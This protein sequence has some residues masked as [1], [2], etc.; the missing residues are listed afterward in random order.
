M[1]ALSPGLAQSALELMRLLQRQSLSTVE[2]LAGLKRIGNIATADA[3]DL[4]QTLNWLSLTTD[5]VLQA[6][7]A[8]ER[9]VAITR[10]D[11]ALRQ[12]ML[13]FVDFV[14]PDWLQNATYGRARVLSFAGIGVAQ[15]L[16]EAGVASGIDD[17]VVG[18]WD[19]LAARARGQ[20]DD[21]MLAIG[22]AGERLSLVYEERRTGKPARWIALDSNQDGYD[23]L[24]IAGEDSRTP[25]TI[26]VKTSTVGL[27]GLIHLTRPEWLHALDSSAH[28]FHLWH[29]QTKASPQLAIIS[30]DEM[31]GHV[32]LDVGTGLWREVRIPFRAFSDRFIATADLKRQP[33]ASDCAK[34][35]R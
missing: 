1:K 9:I 16:V 21:R 23:I 34:A 7:M 35:V 14:R 31:E 10:Y 13:D 11:L 26:E 15:T 29:L 19:A 20:K 30:P 22:R 18:F 25:L 24:S 8:G 2:L 17:G 12:I 6:T 4:A 3:L 32:P 28:V 33:L 27:S 5:G